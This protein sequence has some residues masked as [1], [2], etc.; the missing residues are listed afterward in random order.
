[1]QA[2]IYGFQAVRKSHTATKRKVG[3]SCLGDERGSGW[4]RGDG[5]L[6]TRAF[7]SLVRL[8][9]GGLFCCRF[10]GLYSDELKTE[11]RNST[12]VGDEA[13]S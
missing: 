5:V 2:C 13:M 1:M 6:S 3:D 9:T 11:R 8:K 7:F 10:L 12:H 4:R